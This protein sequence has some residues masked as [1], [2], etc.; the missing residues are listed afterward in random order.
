[1]TD[2]TKLAEA[3]L[4]VGVGEHLPNRAGWADSYLPPG[5][6][7]GNG[8]YADAFINDGRTVLALENAVIGKPNWYQ[9]VKDR[10]CSSVPVCRV[11]IYDI[12]G[13]VVAHSRHDDSEVAIAEACLRALGMLDD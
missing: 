13:E 12:E 6:K 10:K 7:T 9:I 4:K 3:A 5:V 8:L 11:W 2:F 1:M